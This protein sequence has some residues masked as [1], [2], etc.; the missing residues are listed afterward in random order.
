MRTRQL[1]NEQAE[2]LDLIRPLMLLDAEFVQMPCDEFLRAVSVTAHSRDQEL[3]VIDGEVLEE[4]QE[5]SNELREIY[6]GDSIH[7]V[8]CNILGIPAN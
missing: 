7:E 1:I 8:H 2:H 5:I 6:G 3:I 4:Y